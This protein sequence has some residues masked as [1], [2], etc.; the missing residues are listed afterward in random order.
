MHKTHGLSKTPTYRTWADMRNRCQN[1]NNQAYANYGGRGIIVSERWSSYLNFLSDMGE[2]PSKL[3]SIER[4]DTNGPYSQ[5]NCCWATKI[6]QARNTRTNKFISYDGEIKTLAE[7]CEI[8]ALPYSTI[9]SRLRALKWTV[10]RAF[11]TPTDT[12]F[13]RP[14]IG[15][16]SRGKDGKFS[17]KRPPE[18]KRKRKQK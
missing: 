3:H 8:L 2:K 4:V 14:S 15:R 17:W 5:D 7:W 10:E 1:P 9:E 12:Y 11:T 6:T 13:K 16:P 18:E